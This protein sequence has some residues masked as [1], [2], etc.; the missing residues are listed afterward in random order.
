MTA[1]PWEQTA[2]FLA[3]SNTDI[4]AGGPTAYVHPRRTGN[5]PQDVTSFHP[6]QALWSRDN[7]PETFYVLLPTQG[8]KTHSYSKR[9]DKKRDQAGN[10]VWEAKP[11]PG[12]PARAL[13]DFKILPDKIGTKEEY[14]CSIKT[15]L[16]FLLSLTEMYFELWRRLD[17]RIRWD[18]ILMRMEVKNRPKGNALNMAGFRVWR[19]KLYMVAWHIKGTK[20]G[21][22]DQQAKVLARLSPAQVAANTTRGSTPGLLNPVLGPAGRRTVGIPWPVLPAGRGETK[23]EAEPETDPDEDS[24][25][26]P[27]RKRSKP[28]HDSNVLDTSRM[29]TEANE[30]SE[31]NRHEGAFDCAAAPRPALGPAATISKPLGQYI[32][33]NSLVTTDHA[34]KGSVE[35]TFQKAKFHN[36][37]LMQKDTSEEDAVEEEAA[38]EYALTHQASTY[39]PQINI[40][41]PLPG[42]HEPRANIHEQ[43]VSMYE[44]LADVY[45]SAESD[46]SGLEQHTLIYRGMMCEPADD[47]D[48]EPEYHA[49]MRQVATFESRAIMYEPANKV[50]SETV[51]SALKRRALTYRPTDDVNVEPEDHA[52]AQQPM[53]N[54]SVNKY[55]GELE[56]HAF[57]HQASAYEPASNAY[58][59]PEYCALTQQATK[60]DSAGAVSS[61]SEG[62]AAIN[63][64]VGIELA[65]NIVGESEPQAYKAGTRWSTM[66][67]VDHAVELVVSEALY[68]D[69]PEPD[70]WYTGPV[71]NTAEDDG[72][73]YTGTKASNKLV[74]LP[75]CLWSTSQVL[76][77]VPVLPGKIALKAEDSQG[78]CHYQKSETDNLAISSFQQL[79][80][81]E[82]AGG[83]LAMALAEYQEFRASGLAYQKRPL[84]NMFRSKPETPIFTW[85]DDD[86]VKIMAVNFLTGA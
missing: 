21:R 20:N 34:D 72:P 30:S 71:V 74:A 48:G 11:E 81:Q 46:T 59:Q 58:Y 27:R 28:K 53:M 32:F 85:D 10:I 43:Q 35:G 9:P 36:E 55:D 57:M 17:G 3:A 68:R 51:Y 79:H 16:T 49:L 54:K 76:P 47:V 23:R 13:L 63:Q 14:V 12:K 6:G 60:I 61:E 67:I 80:H 31:Q 5:S 44:P 1:I 22:G 86:T 75:N 78:N 33:S 56:D 25:D 82:T 52:P 39:E 18:D 40:Y 29:V 37:Y 24:D 8:W 73:Q 64:A 4:V 62:N 41:Q 69:E 65:N 2:E 26:A 50:A 45:E 77:D 84:V 7:L 19:P 42:Q 70:G 38:R 66:P 15:R 83:T